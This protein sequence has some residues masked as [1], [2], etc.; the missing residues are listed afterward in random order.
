MAPLSAFVYTSSF[1]LLGSDLGAT[2]NG[3]RIQQ[4]LL[5]LVWGHLAN[6]S[7]GGRLGDDMEPQGSDRANSKHA[8][9]F[10]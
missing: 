6:S 3:E 7:E 10:L 5:S 4:G 9:N 2:C 8:D 1:R